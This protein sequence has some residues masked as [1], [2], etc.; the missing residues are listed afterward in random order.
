M[1]KKESFAM[2][3]LLSLLMEIGVNENNEKISGY[4]MALNVD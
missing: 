4:S 3:D 2:N 1:K